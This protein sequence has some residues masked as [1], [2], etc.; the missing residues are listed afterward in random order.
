MKKYIHIAKQFKPI[1]TDQAATKISEAYSELRSY[2][3]EHTDMAK[4][5]SNLLNLLKIFIPKIFSDST[6]YSKM[7]RNYDSSSNRSC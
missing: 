5:V 3:Q 6:C 1:L 2:D 7:L 4:V